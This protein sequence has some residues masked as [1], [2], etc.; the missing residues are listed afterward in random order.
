MP[1]DRHCLLAGEAY[2][3]ADHIDGFLAVTVWER[4]RGSRSV[5]AFPIDRSAR[6]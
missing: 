6:F 2:V 1:S 5:A 3:A 4:I